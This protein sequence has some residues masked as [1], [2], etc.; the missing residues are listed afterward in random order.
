MDTSVDGPKG[1]VMHSKIERRKRRKRRKK[2]IRASCSQRLA[3]QQ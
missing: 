3:G 2:E 1:E